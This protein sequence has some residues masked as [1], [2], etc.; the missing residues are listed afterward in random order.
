LK[1]SVWHS[2]QFS[3]VENGGKFYKMTKIMQ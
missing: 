2:N 3:E 1:E